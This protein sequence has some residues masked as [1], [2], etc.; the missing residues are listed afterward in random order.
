MIWIIWI[1]T[2]WNRNLL[3]FTLMKELFRPVSL[4]SRTSS[5]TESVIYY[6]E[7]QWYIPNASSPTPVTRDIRKS[8]CRLATLVI[9][10]S[11]LVIFVTVKPSRVHQ[12]AV[13]LQARY[14]LSHK[15]VHKQSYIKK[16]WCVKSCACSYIFFQRLL[17]A[18][19]QQYTTFLSL[20]L[21][22]VRSG[23]TLQLT[24]EA[25]FLPVKCAFTHLVKDFFIVLHMKFDQ[26]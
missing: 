2:F 14:L 7:K 21:V 12:P 24:A 13:R 4:R 9:V 11:H 22:L 16:D 26:N 18:H 25:L 5:S 6:N 10:S 3:Y 19:A 23:L 8:S 20:S 15:G 1:I 17:E